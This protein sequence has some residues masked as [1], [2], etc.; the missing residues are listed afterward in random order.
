MVKG[1]MTLKIVEKGKRKDV[2]IKEGEIFLLPE[3]IPHSPQVTIF[4]VCL[5]ESIK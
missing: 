1:D 2:V 5:K 4:F 3:R